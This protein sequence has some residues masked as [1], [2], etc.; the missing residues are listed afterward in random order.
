MDNVSLDVPRG[1]IFSLL[2]RNGAGKTTF[3]KIAS[4]QLMPS[5]GDLRVL[6]F[7]VVSEAQEIRKRIALT[8]QEGRPALL[9][10]P[11]EHVFHYLLARG[12]SIFE[13]SART[14]KTLKELDMMEYAHRTCSQLSGGLRQ[15][16]LAAMALATDADLLFLDEPTLG[17]DVLTRMKV[18]EVIR[19]AAAENGQ[20]VFLTTHYMEEAETLSDRVGIIE[21]GRLV[22]VGHVS[23]V[24]EA[25]GE[26]MCVEISGYDLDVEMLR[27]VGQVLVL[28]R[29][30]R[31]LAD[32]K[33]CD[34]L[35]EWAVRAGKPSI[36]R[37]ASLEDAFIALVGRG[38]ED[39]G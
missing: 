5:G 35:L 15:R 11:Y 12:L 1:C 10:T 30:V 36:F 25:L 31:V 14:L 22:K 37:P 2:G 21:G 16:T 26:K 24:K 17:L 7:D 23:D 6:G 33:R 19:R 3:I 27:E 9:N 4:T 32:K 34:E 28:G 38:V 29:S 39:E 13:A 8:P 18:W 20:T